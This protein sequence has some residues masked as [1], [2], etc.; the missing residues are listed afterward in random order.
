MALSP[1]RQQVWTEVHMAMAAASERGVICSHTAN[2]GEVTH[3]ANPTGVGTAPVG[4]LLDDVE[5][6]NFDRHGEYRNRMVVD[7]GSVVGLAAKGDYETNLVV[8]TPA[9]GDVAYLA[10]SGWVSPTQLTDGITAA[11]AVGR[12]RTG[13]NANGFALVHIDL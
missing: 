4:L 11:P 7:V 8:G 2:P 9:P 5:A 1:R 3:L 13:K 10:A 6:M 12:F